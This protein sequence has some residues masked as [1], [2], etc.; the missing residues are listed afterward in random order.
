[1]DAGSVGLRPYRGEDLDLLARLF[2]DPAVMGR[3][4]FGFRDMGALRRRWE[5]DG[6][7]GADDGQLMVTV[8]GGPAGIV[9]WSTTGHGAGR[10]PGIGIVLLPEWR[11]RRVGSRAQ[12]LLCGYLFAHAPIQRIEA[13]TQPDNLAERRALASVGFRQEAVRRSAEF[14]AGRWRDI[15]V[16]GL[17]RA[18]LST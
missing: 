9:G 3:N 5:T 12:R 15:V 18:E 1:M 6:W 8:D 10:Y 17:V 4:W 14:R 2:N 16:Y 7:L 11:G 13:L